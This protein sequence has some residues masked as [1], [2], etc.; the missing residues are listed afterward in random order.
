MGLDMYAWAVPANQC[1]NAQVDYQPDTHVIKNNL[2]YWRKFNHLH[3]WM[4]R[5]YRHKEGKRTSFN[6]DS[7]RL[8]EEDLT[9]LELVLLENKLPYQ[10]GFF[11]G[12]ANIDLEDILTTQKFIADAREAIKEGKAVFYDS[13]W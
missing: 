11:F 5:L 1:N 3:G 6:C 9:A 2:A 10:P 8:N 12:S 13:W 4:E 7:V